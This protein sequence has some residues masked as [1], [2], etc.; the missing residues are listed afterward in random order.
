MVQFWL[1]NPAFLINTQNFDYSNQNTTEKKIQI[2]NIIAMTSLII[3]L[4]FVY[5]KKNANY[6]GIS[7]IIMAFTILLK[8]NLSSSFTSVK[9][10]KGIDSNAFDTGV[11]LV[12]NVSQNDPSGLNNVLYV[13]EALNFNKGD[14]IALSNNNSV[15]E[16]NIVADIK[17]TTNEGTP[18]IVLLKPIKGT[19][20]KY[21]TKILKVSDTAPGI[22]PPPDG[23]VSIQNANNTGT[24]DPMKMATQG[25]HK[26]NLPNQN[27]FDWNL[28]QSSM[29]PGGDDNYVYQGQPN[30]PL[31]CRTSDI[32]N[33][34]GT[35]NVT[36]YDSPP[37]MYGKCNV[38]ETTDGKYNDQLMTENQEAT[39]PQRV[40]DLLFHKGNSQM[41]FSPT[42]VDTLPDN[43]AAFANFCYNSPTNLVNAKYASIFV[44]DPEKYKIVAKLARATGT[45]NGGGGGGGGRP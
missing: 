30:G 33:P 12:K 6:F 26:F 43:R 9:N 41:M 13:T 18:V 35:I 37:T 36:E 16:T 39:V 32:N 14:V 15:L 44:N 40:N 17:Y 29:V 38:A 25:Y 34:M 42:P 28:E 10:P 1:D 24:S 5:K 23:N 20:S 27:R 21:T 3:G 8:S 45:E 31:K 2:L 7:V 4:F 22:I 11:S 19:Y